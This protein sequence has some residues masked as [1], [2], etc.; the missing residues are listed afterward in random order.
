MN[1][2][3]QEFGTEDLIDIVTANKGHSATEIISAVNDSVD[4][5][6]GDVPPN[7]DRTMI[8]VKVK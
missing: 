7:D 5:F 1:E 3:L 6:C 2:K 4:S 8:V